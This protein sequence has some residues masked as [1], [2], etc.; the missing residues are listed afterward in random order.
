MLLSDCSLHSRLFRWC[1]L[2]SILFTIF[3]RGILVFSMQYCMFFRKILV[4]ILVF[5]S[6]FP[7]NLQVF[8]ASEDSFGLNISYEETVPN[9]QTKLALVKKFLGSVF[10]PYSFQGFSLLIDKDQ[11]E[12][13]GKVQGKKMTLSPHVKTDT[14]FLKLFVHE[15]GHFV[16]IHLIQ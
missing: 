6:V 13:R 1:V 9:I 8:S 14:E 5:S 4:F 16:D 11:Y 3:H 12:P 15:V 10:V 2:S 7:L